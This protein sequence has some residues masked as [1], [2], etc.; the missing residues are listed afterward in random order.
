MPS[1]TKTFSNRMFGNVAA[2]KANMAEQDNK[3][4]RSLLF[5][6]PSLLFIIIELISLRP[7]TQYKH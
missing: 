5:T 2:N 1:K 3:V 4:D 7:Y 6:F